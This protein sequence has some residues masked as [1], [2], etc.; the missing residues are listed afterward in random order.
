MVLVMKNGWRILDEE[1]FYHGTRFHRRISSIP[2]ALHV[3]ESRWRYR[4]DGYRY[5]YIYDE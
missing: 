3:N 1:L 5:G 4:K 2:L